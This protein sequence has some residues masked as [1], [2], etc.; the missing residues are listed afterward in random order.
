M[1]L[2]DE[3]RNVSQR[4]VGSRKGAAVLKAKATKF[5]ESV[6]PLLEQDDLAGFSAHAT[7]RELN[8][9]GVPTPRGGAWKAN[10]V[11]KLKAR[12]PNRGPAEHPSEGPPSLCPR[13]RREP[14]AA[15]LDHLVG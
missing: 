13:A 15:S 14:R 7:A 4:E 5:A 10:S 1:R 11:L 8:R 6:R 3:G 2:G 9:R 12:L